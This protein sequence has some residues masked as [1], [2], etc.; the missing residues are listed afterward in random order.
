MD[1]GL[2]HSAVA[3][4]VITGALQAWAGTAAPASSGCPQE[5]LRLG[6]P[7]TVT[8]YADNGPGT[9][10][11]ALLD[12]GYGDRIDFDAAAFPPASP[13]PI[14]LQSALPALSQGAVTLDASGA[15][16]ILDGSATTSAV[17]ITVAS[18]SNTIRGLQILNFPAGGL[19]LAEGSDGNTV[20]GNVI[21]SNGGSCGLEIIG[22]GNVVTGNLIGTDVS[23][24]MDLGNSGAGICIGDSSGNRIGPGNLIAHNGGVGIVV[25]GALATGNRVTQNS[26]TDNALEGIR[27]EEGANSGIPAPTITVCVETSISGTA[28]PNCTIEVFSDSDGEG[29][30]YEGNTASD[31]SGAFAFTKPEGLAGPDITATATDSSGNT[32][33]FSAPAG[34]ATQPATWGVIKARFQR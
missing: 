31:G 24:S 3:I 27:L 14:M 34:V 6:T 17:G 28:P 30:T 10:R 26:I 22:S 5:V 29:E 13:V 20:E 32:S 4:I 25:R 15:G 33:P 12:A 11:Q 19:L 16:V 23:G 2:W 18:D 8:S 9:L 1:K 7:W 21:S